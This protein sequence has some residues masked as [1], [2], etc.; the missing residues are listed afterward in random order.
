MSSSRPPQRIGVLKPDFGSSGGLER[1]LDGL[2]RALASD[3]WRFE[4]VTIPVERTMRLYGLLLDQ[5]IRDRH[6]EFFLWAA[7]AERVQ[8]LDLSAYD[9]VLTTQPPTYLA[10]HPRKVALFYH[11]PRQFYDQA[12]L[13]ADSGFVDPEI[14]A[15]AVGGAIGRG[16]GAPNTVA[17]WLAGSNEV[18]PVAC[19]RSGTCPTTD[20]DPLGA[21]HVGPE[22][23]RAV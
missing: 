19:D 4:I 16:N 2:L 5:P 18:A 8:R 22:L 9:A 11:H 17:H 14:H 10:N 1:H 21:S 12:D 3:E 15:A 7:L 23:H 20:H 13:F 6:D